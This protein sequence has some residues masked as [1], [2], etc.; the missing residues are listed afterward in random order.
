M[1]KVIL[2]L[3]LL[4]L[5]GTASAHEGFR[6]YHGGY[7]NSGSWVAPA[8]IGGVIGFFPFNADAN[9]R[10][11]VEASSADLINTAADKWPQ[12][13]DRLLYAAKIF[14]QNKMSD[15]ALKLARDAAK[16]NPRNFDA[17]YYI[18][19]APSTS[20]NEKREILDRLKAL[21]P[22]NPDLAKLG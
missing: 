14:D 22:H 21:D 19:N 11:S 9:F 6:H 8:I 18:Y 5:A 16:L 13:P 2:A 3:S 4:A 1:K 17:W 10:H 12:T 20:G 15:K 7:Y